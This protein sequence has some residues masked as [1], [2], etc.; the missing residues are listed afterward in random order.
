MNHDLLYSKELF[1]D[2]V[3]TVDDFDVD[4]IVQ[5]YGSK[6][7]EL[8]RRYAENG[9]MSGIHQDSRPVFTKE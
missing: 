2:S 6:A 5:E 4:R 7:T 3:F 9:F 8:E 1:G